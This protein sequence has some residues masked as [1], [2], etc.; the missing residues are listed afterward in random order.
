[1]TCGTSLFVVLANRVGLSGF[2]NQ[3]VNWSV[4]DMDPRYAMNDELLYGF[5]GAKAER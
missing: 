4:I 1:M 5:S 2:Y 3:T